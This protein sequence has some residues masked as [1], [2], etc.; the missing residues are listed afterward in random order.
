MKRFAVLMAVFAVVLTVPFGWLALRAYG[1]LDREEQAEFQF[2]GEA[3]FDRIEERMAALLKREEERPV[4]DY[5]VG[6]GGSSPLASLTGEKYIVGYLQLDADGTPRPIIGAA[7]AP[8]DGRLWRAALEFQRFSSNRHE[9]RPAPSPAG[10]GDGAAEK[11][12]RA[13][14]RDQA[15]AGKYFRGAAPPRGYLE[16]QKQPRYLKAEE[17]AQ[18]AAQAPA[19]AVS[20][21]GR[22]REPGAIAKS[23]AAPVLAYRSWVAPMEAV[24]LPDDALFLFR[25]VGTGTGVVVQGLVLDVGSFLDELQSACF[26][27]EPVAAFSRLE[28]T[29][30]TPHGDLSRRFGAASIASGLE[31]E[32]RFPRPFG[33]FR[34]RL[35]A[36]SLPPSPGRSLLNRLLPALGGV[37]A[38]GLFLIYR[39]ARAIHDLSLRRSGFAS[40]VSHE[41]KTPLTNIRLYADMLREGVAAS[42]E[43][44]R[45]YLDVI[46]S[47]SSRLTRLINAVL[48]FSKLE[49][50]SRVF[51]LRPHLLSELAAEVEEVLAGQLKQEGFEVRR[52]LPDG[53]RVVCD[54]EALVR[55]LI[56]C[57]ENSIKFGRGEPLRQIRISAEK[58]GREVILE[59]ADSG[60]GIAGS[61]LKRV[62]EDFFRGDDSL[63]RKTEGTGI[64]LA[65]VRQLA[66]GMGGRVEARNNPGRGCTIRVILP[67]RV[68]DQ[69]NP[70]PQP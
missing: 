7:A 52:E 55:I 32:R 27:G 58:K 40:S 54:R 1:N 30:L 63:T 5:L 66:Q 33:Q 60:P 50:G 49:K 20:D 29:F 2:F 12:G 43:K 44:Q 22:E 10:D 11:K 3:L 46:S 16:Q 15:L 37:L 68:P 6:P 26:A 47:E 34:A 14:D 61:D 24:P 45:R 41:L 13:R 48:E 28:L 56:S 9:Q 70:A 67:D 25:R 19:G 35:G 64:G 39:S 53:L 18:L 59:V 69:R 62:F 21:A 23:G 8:D 4:G 57:V 38:L 31:L 65:L 51:D 17:I 42:P 36:G